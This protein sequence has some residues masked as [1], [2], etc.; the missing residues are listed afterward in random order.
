MTVALA[1][2][3]EPLGMVKERAKEPA[4]GMV[5][6][7]ALAIGNCCEDAWR[8]EMSSFLLIA[9][10]TEGLIHVMLALMSIRHWAGTLFIAHR[11]W[12]CPGAYKDEVAAEFWSEL[13]AT[14]E[15]TAKNP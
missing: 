3:A 7:V 9:S 13:W 4:V 14:R 2:M 6:P 10:S 12:L 1:V 15:L 11:T 5:E 8:L